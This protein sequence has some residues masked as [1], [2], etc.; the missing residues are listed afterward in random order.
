MKEYRERTGIHWR[1][2]F[3]ELKAGGI[4]PR[5]PPVMFMWPTEKIGDVHAVLSPHGYWTCTGG[6]R[7]C[8]DTS[9]PL[10]LELEVVANIPKA[11][12]IK[13]FIS[14]FEA[15]ALIGMAET[16]LGV[17]HVGGKEQG[18]LTSRTRTSTNA[19][20]A[21]H[22]SPLTETI[23]RRTA[24]VLNI[25]ESL[26]HHS[27]LA[28]DIQ[29]V[30]YAKDQ[31]YESHH[32]WGISATEVSRLLT[33]LIYLTDQPSVDAGGETSFAKGVGRDGNAFKVRPKKGSAILFYNLL[34][35]GNGDDLAL[36]AALPV[37]QGEKYAANI[38]V[39]DPAR[40]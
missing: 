7:K 36:H 25:H 9:A 11:L 38:W 37:T 12:L 18:S 31:K 21:R 13:D 26:L 16:R 10:S 34:E 32:D 33:L 30:H 15:E 14:D 17:S 20:L 22:T 3:G 2:F 40:A 29:V 19:W 1:H 6:P 4:G 28:E 23:Y 39:W 35:D 8:H 27:G 24:D 5:P